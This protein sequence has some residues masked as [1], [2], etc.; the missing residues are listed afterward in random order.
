[1]LD[2]AGTYHV[3]RHIILPLSL[4]ALAT[5][6][7]FTFQGVWNDFLPPL[8][9]LHDQSLYTVTLGLS[10]FRSTYTVNWAYLMAA[11]LVTVLP[12]VL[13]FLLAQRLFIEGIAVTGVKG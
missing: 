11:S 4:P 2:G 7:V 13:V 1:M 8:I 9:Y 10:F 5:V 3:I 12:V 6:A